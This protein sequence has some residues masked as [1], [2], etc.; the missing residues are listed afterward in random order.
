MKSNHSTVIAN[1]MPHISTK[2]IKRDRD[3]REFF[4]FT[5]PTPKRVEDGKI[6]TILCCVGVKTFLVLG[7]A[8]FNTFWA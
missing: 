8:I 7:F 1:A 5:G 2:I 4:I 3:Y 6:P